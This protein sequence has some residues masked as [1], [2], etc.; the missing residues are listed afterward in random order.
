MFYIKQE[1]DKMCKIELNK[2]GAAQLWEDSREKKNLL[3]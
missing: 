2:T 1:S 3:S